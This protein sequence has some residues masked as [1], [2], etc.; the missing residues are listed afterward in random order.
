M[1]PDKTN[2]LRRGE[3][4]R[5]FIKKSGM[6]AAALAGAGL[7]SIPVSAREDS[8]AVSIVL[9]E[10]DAVIKEAPVQWAVEQLRDALVARGVTTQIYQ[11]LDPA[12]VSQEC[13][14]VAGRNSNLS[15]HILDRAGIVLPNTPEAMALARGK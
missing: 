10:S 7:L 8:P 6:A 11:S 15:K 12:P 9:D 2:P 4:R 1:R 14:L 5:H 3:T 13:V